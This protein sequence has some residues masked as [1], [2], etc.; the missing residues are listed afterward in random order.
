MIVLMSAGSRLDILWLS[1]F[2]PYPAKG[3]ALQRSHHL[4]R[5]AAQRHAVHLVT[6]NQRAILP[7]VSHVSDDAV[8]HVLDVSKAPV[9][10]SHSSCRAICDHPRNLPDALVRE[11]ARRDG[12]V[13]ANS[14]MRS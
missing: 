7:D 4:L 13:M 9:V 3:G 2:L 12:V 10:A 6:L 11:I 1:H 8:L 14:R 5:A